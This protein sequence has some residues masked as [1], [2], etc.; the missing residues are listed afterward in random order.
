MLFFTDKIYT[1]KNLSRLSLAVMLFGS[2]SGCDVANS[3]SSGATGPDPGVFD[4]PIA[5]IKRP[6]YV[7]NNDNPVQEDIRNPLIFSAGGD[8]YLKSRSSASAAEINITSGI[9]SGLGDVKDIDVSYD[10]R[11]LLFSLRLEDPNPNDNVVPSWNIYEYDLDADTNQLRRIISDNTTAERGNDLAPHYLADGRIV[12]TSTRQRQSR[13]VLTNEGITG[14]SKAPFSSLDE[15]RRTKALVLHV[16]NSDGT[17]IQQI[18]F[19]QSHDLDPLV[20]SSGEILFSR[21][22]RMNSKNAISLYKVTPD[23]T[24]LQMVYGVHDESHDTGTGNSTIEFIKPRETEDGKIIAISRPFTGTFGGGEIIVIDT[25]NYIDYTRPIISQTGLTGPAH[26]AVT[27]NNILTDGSISKAGY[28]HAAYPLWDGTGRLL[29]SK[30]LCQLAINNITRACIEPYLSDANAQ[31]LPPAY[32]IWIYDAVS[33]T[34][35]P[36]VTAEQGMMLTDV[37]AMQLRNLPDYIS[38]KS[39]PTD[40]NATWISEGVGVLHIR[41]VYDFGDGLFN[42]CFLTDCTSAVNINNVLDFADPVNATADQR[43]ARFMRFYKA[44]GIPD[45]NDPDLVDPPNLRA[46][47]FGRTALFGMR[48]IV[49]YAPIEPDGSIKVKVPANIPLSFEIVDKQGKRI[50]NE[51]HQNWLQVRPGDTVNCSGCHTHNG[52]A[53]NLPHARID[54]EAGSINTGAPYDG[55]LWPNSEQP[56]SSPATE[57]WANAGETMAESR[58][59]LFPSALTPSLNVIYDD[60][61]TDA[62]KAGRSKDVSFTYDYT[63]VDG[64]DTLAPATVAC[65]AAWAATCR[66]VINYIDHIQPLWEV[67]RGAMDTDTCINCHT[68]NNFTTLPAGQ[69]DLSNITSDEQPDHIESY[70]ELLFQ[71]N[72]VEVVGGSLIDIMITVPVLDADGNQQF[73]INGNLI[74]EDIPDPAAGVN[75]AMTIN[76]A[77]SSAAFFNRFSLPGDQ[78][79]NM[80]STA[81]IRLISE[82]LDMGAQYFNNPFDSRVPQN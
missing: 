72:G 55:Y 28:Y 52:A 37:V 57:Y 33:N 77:R 41:S 56:G 5:Y 74:T 24:S 62:V 42:G 46:T 36:I 14:I 34:E 4:Y 69:L 80:L 76:G 47:A 13:E 44:V 27:I 65:E 67:A 9:T 25:D 49:G 58:A 75:P 71:D 31:A 39:E 81:E 51:R 60:V 10:G 1:V 64:L 61:W 79:E 30:G 18:S 16:M 48:E 26:N 21:W 70:R 2:I 68:S 20:L 50:G 17:G 22:D 43:P 19:N 7:D 23:G 45:R 32:G 3:D 35:K 53:A 73:D 8:V 82:W 66:T 63:G 40:L 12:F 11:K 59:R 6:V 15:N 78:H 29:V 38:D 54:A